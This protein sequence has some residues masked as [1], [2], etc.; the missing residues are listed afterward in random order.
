MCMKIQNGV[1][2]VESYKQSTRHGLKAV[3]RP[4]TKDARM[5]KL[6]MYLDAY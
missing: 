4:R 6:A 1:P 5:Q 2:M 3:R